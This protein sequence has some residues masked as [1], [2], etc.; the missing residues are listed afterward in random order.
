MLAGI[1]FVVWRAIELVT[2]IPLIGMLSY[3]VHG[4]VT[5]NL[6]T[7]NYILVLFIVS[8]LAGVWA[9]ATLTF[10]RSARRSG[11]FLALVDL[12]IF[13]GLIAGVVILRGIAGS[14]CSAPTSFSGYYQLGPFINDWGKTCQILKASFGFAIL[15]ILLFFNSFVRDNGIVYSVCHLANDKLVSCD[16]GSPPLPSSAS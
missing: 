10:Y 11:H 4:Y 16:L 5:Q 15:N 6:L 14:D 2:L 8:V 1:L 9:L 7:P 3:L 12:G 13:A